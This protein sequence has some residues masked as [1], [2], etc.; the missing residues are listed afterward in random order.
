MLD[1]GVEGGNGGK[2][3]VRSPTF[4][5][6]TAIPMT[7]SRLISRCLSWSLV[8]TLARMMGFS[9]MASN[10]DLTRNVSRVVF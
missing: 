5:A 10:I 9:S 3:G 6:D 1:N 8:T 7:P 2:D 4:G